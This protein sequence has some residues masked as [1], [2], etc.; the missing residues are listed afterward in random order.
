MIKMVFKWFEFVVTFIT[1]PLSIF[2]PATRRQS[3]QLC[4]FK[5]THFLNEAR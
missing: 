1:E 5:Q 2:I 3:E 4:R